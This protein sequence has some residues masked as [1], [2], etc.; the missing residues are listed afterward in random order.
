MPGCS[1]TLTQ[2]SKPGELEVLAITVHLSVGNLHP[3]MLDQVKSVPD[4]CHLPQD[5]GHTWR[6][7]GRGCSLLK[8]SNLQIRPIK[9]VRG[10]GRWMADKP[11][12]MAKAR[13]GSA[14]MVLA[15]QLQDGRGQQESH[16]EAQPGV[17]EAAETNKILPW[18]GRREPAPESCL[19]PAYVCCGVHTI[20]NN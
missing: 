7:R 18:Q 6:Y 14:P 20:T 1:H 15:P 19:P 11:E 12:S 9:G 2:T 10:A 5:Q 17:C 3:V 4:K 13:R 8:G 16:L